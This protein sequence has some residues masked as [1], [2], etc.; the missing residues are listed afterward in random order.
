MEN[1]GLRFKLVDDISFRTKFNPSLRDKIYTRQK[2]YYQE[3]FASGLFNEYH[4]NHRFSGHKKKSQSD[5]FVNR[6]GELQWQ[7]KRAEH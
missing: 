6:R 1:M 4:E 3:I 5:F 7:K 2:F